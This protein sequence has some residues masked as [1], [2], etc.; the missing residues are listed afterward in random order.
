VPKIAILFGSL[1]L[2]TSFHTAI[3]SSIAAG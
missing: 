1:V 3:A 2:T